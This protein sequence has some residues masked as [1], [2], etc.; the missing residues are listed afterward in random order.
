MSTMLGNNPYT[1]EKQ[2]RLRRDMDSSSLA[3][4][5]AT[6]DGSRRSEA[7]RKGYFAALAEEQM[8]LSNLGTEDV[9]AAMRSSWKSLVCIRHRKI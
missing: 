1:A 4:M 6:T 5:L 8:A 3:G 2:L 9:A 7:G